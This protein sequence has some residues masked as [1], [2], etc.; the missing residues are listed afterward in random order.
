MKFHW[1]RM[2]VLG[3]AAACLGCAPMSRGQGQLVHLNPGPGPL[4]N[5]LKGWCTYTTAGPIH[6]P[7]SMVYQY[8]SWKDLEP[9]EGDYQFDAWEK[10]AWN[11]P[12]AA[13]KR[14]VF[15][16]YLDYPSLPSGVPDWVVAKGV[17]M[18]K[19]T[20]EGGG[21]SPDYENPILIS[22]LERLIAALGKRYDHDPRV[23]FVTVGTLG[24][25]GEW[26][27]YPRTELFASPA[28]QQRIVDAYR[29]AFPDKQL[30]ARYPDGVTGAQG[31]LGY[32]DDMFPSDT[33]GPDTWMFL[34]KMERSGRTDN[35]KA[36]PIGGE[37]EPGAA[38][39]WLGA[40]FARTMAAVEKAHMTW[41]GPYSPAIAPNTSPEFLANCQAMVRRM[42]YQFSLRTVQASVT[43]KSSR[44]LRVVIEGEN[45]GV[46]PFYYRWPVR[47][48]LIG[49]NH[50]VAQTLSTDADIRAWRPGPFTLSATQTVHLLPGAYRLGLGVIDP[51]TGRPGV[52]FANTLPGDNGW[53]ILTN[54]RVP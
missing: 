15:R 18:R 1:P 35:W 33:T 44:S 25:W 4:D 43:G 47:L 11:I 3:L 53:T 12:S 39:R 20:E 42:G 13:G 32:H 41:V 22:N 24:F 28:T 48:A 5:P 40:D 14:V 9:R 19:Y 51:M 34:P 50:Q 27:T 16:V 26:H 49:A 23:A 46:A 8:A 31:W 21:L 6:Q 38:N 37:M 52:K 7:Y 45:Q 54:V 30:Q 36:A 17:Q 2:I 29:R 10:R